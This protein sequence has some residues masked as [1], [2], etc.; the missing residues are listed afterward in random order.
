MTPLLTG[1][2][3][4]DDYKDMERNLCGVYSALGDMHN[5]LGITGWLD[6]APRPFFNRSYQVIAADRFANALLAAITSE[7]LRAIPIRIGAIDQFIDSPDYIENV[8]MYAR[9]RRLFERAQ[10]N[11]G[12]PDQDESDPGNPDPR[13]P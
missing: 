10:G 7:E 4:A 11:P 3:R 6:P 1:A 5:A 13:R 12:Q 9:T 2:L 8:E